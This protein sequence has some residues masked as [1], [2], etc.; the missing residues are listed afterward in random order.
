MAST[1]NS[2]SI[3]SLIDARRG[4]VFAGV[5]DSKL[6]VILED[7]YIKLDIL[8]DEISD[9]STFVS[10]DEFE[11]NTIK[12]NYDIIKIIKKH[13]FDDSVDPHKLVPNY[14]KMTEAEEKRT[15]CDRNS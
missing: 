12:P 15:N 1:C 11:F 8:K 7:Q 3:V 4:Y 5:Y 13:E 2:N 9:N 14:L 6:N 10:L